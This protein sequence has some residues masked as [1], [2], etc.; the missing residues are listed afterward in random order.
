MPL[1]TIK[2]TTVSGVVYQVDT[3]SGPVGVGGMGQVYRGLRVDTNTGV[4]QEVAIKFLFDDLPP[5]SI[6]RARREASICIN[7]ENL[8]RM[9][10]FIETTDTLA[11]GK[12]VSHY[13]VVSEF[14]RGV[15]LEDL[16]KGK[17]ENGEGKRSAVAE[18]MYLQSR[19]QPE[20]FAVNVVKS[21]LA[22]VMA[23]HDQGV[24]HRDIDPSNIM[25]TDD[26]KIKLIDYGIA[27][28]LDD[29]NTR[30]RQLTTAGVFMGKAAYASPE[31]V[32]GDINHQNETTDIYAIGVILFQLLTGHLPFSGPTSE[33]LDMQIN[34]PVPV[35]E[36]REPA[37]RKIVAK[38]MAKKQ[39]DRFASAAEFRVA[40]EA[41]NRKLRPRGIESEGVEK[42]PPRKPSFKKAKKEETPV[43]TNRTVTVRP[44]AKKKIPVK[45]IGIIAGAAAALLL[46]IGGISLISNK[47]SQKKA[48]KQEEALARAR[49]EAIA[50]RTLELEGV[51]LDSA[52][53]TV[54]QTDSLTGIVLYSAGHYTQEAVKLLKSEATFAQGKEML[55][56]V[57]AENKPSSADA[58]A[59]MASL[60]TGNGTFEVLGLTKGDVEK[61]FAKAIELNNKALEL[62]GYCYYALCNLGLIY[63]FPEQNVVKRDA[64]KGRNLLDQSRTLAV[65][66]GDTAFEKYVDNMI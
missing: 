2:D 13:H 29:L 53:P 12:T 8:V 55:E 40:V 15:M 66:K 17:V 25:V 5:Q 10:G 6:E 49:Q 56:K 9:Y 11:N 3:S 36:I 23:L 58:Y 42:R 63:S 4:Q 54:T 52:D 38:A 41:V 35:K 51:M 48:A 64:L 45:L 20:L 7:N 28:R 18:E 57:M 39:A 62:Y 21:V 43:E 30:D 34:D 33:V 60:Y 14:L 32:L 27:K 61:D 50:Q 47:V 37:F 65:A 22:G 24:I 46:V 59:V 26:G 31:L 16:L 44:N 19:Q 1:L